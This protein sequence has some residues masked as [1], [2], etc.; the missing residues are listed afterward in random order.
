MNEIWTEEQL[1]LEG[2]VSW[3]LDSLHTTPL[4]YTDPIFLAHRSGHGSRRRNRTLVI[5]SSKTIQAASGE[6]KEIS[7][8][9]HP[10]HA[11]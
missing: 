11:R 5:G 8:V 7:Q 2:Q 1:E 6:E 4:L 10:S 9:L 3:R